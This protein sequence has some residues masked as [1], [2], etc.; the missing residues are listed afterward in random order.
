M[1]HN[2][3]NRNE[4]LLSTGKVIY[5]YNGVL[6]IDNDFSVYGGYDDAL[7]NT[8]FRRSLLGGE[9]PHLNVDE[10]RKSWLTQEERIELAQHA[11]DLWKRYLEEAEDYAS[12]QAGK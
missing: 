1:R 12:S 2:P 8:P 5:V 7:D 11:I 3:E 9:N 4:Y 10:E 6:G